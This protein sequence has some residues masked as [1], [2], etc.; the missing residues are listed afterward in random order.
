MRWMRDT[1]SAEVVLRRF[2]FPHQQRLRR[3]DR[4]AAIRNPEIFIDLRLR[5]PISLRRGRGE[6]KIKGRPGESTGLPCKGRAWKGVLAQRGGYRKRGPWT[7]PFDG[8]QRFPLAAGAEA[9]QP[10]HLYNKRNV[11][12]WTAFLKYIFQA[13]PDMHKSKKRLYLYRRFFWTNIT[14]FLKYI[15][16]GRVQ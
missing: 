4:S 2:F 12:K 5:R 13:V 14:P 7:R 10:L 11:P 1:A 16:S 15:F 3:R 8:A 9:D 6:T